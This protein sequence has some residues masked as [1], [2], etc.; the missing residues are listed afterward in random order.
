L[1]GGGLG[2]G[3]GGGTAGGKKKVR[4]REGNRP[5]YFCSLETRKTPAIN[6]SKEKGLGRNSLSEGGGGGGHS[7][8][9]VTRVYVVEE[10]GKK[11]P[12]LV[13][14]GR[15]RREGRGNKWILSGGGVP[16]KLYRRRGSG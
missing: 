2:E 4:R 14:E 1:E 9:L 7:R 15:G 11:T 16:F 5:F 10:A 12:S 8:K 13:E 3:W 6:R